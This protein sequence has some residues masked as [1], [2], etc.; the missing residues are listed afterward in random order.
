MG[1][2][3]VV[4]WRSPQLHSCSEVAQGFGAEPQSPGPLPPPPLT[5]PLVELLCAGQDG[6]RPPKTM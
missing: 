6:L 5:T 4:W 1:A 3:S 2:P